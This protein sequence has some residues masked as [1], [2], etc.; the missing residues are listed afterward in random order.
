MAFV[1][2]YARPLE[3]PFP[4]DRPRKY[5]DIDMRT[6]LTDK[7]VLLVEDEM[8]VAMLIEQVLLDEK[9][10]IVGP[11]TN[12]SDALSA[13]HTE[14]IDIAILD[15]NL[16][17]ERVFPVADVLISRA[18]PFLFLSGYGADAIPSGHP[19]W[20]VCAKPFRANVLTELVTEMLGAAEMG[21]ETAGQS[22]ARG[23]KTDGSAIR[24]LD[25]NQA[26]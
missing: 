11:F 26:R 8:L 4:W 3:Q 20:R 17:G 23:D 2:R 25:C 16:R 5:D 13:A 9:C 21:K 14:T 19:E 1:Q 22:T 12:L 10:Q 24:G 7:R 18:I 6:I 15:V